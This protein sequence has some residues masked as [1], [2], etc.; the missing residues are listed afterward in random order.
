M[1]QIFAVTFVFELP[2]DL[3]LREPVSGLLLERRSGQWDGWS[4]EG[5]RT[6]LE[7]PPEANLPPDVGPGTRFTLRRQVVRSHPPLLAADRAFADWVEPLLSRSVRLV[8]RVRLGYWRL[9]GIKKPVTVVAV[10]RLVG[11]QDVPQAPDDARALD[12]YRL[13]KPD[14]DRW[15]SLLGLATGR[16]WLS[17]VTDRELPAYIAVITELAGPHGR[18]PDGRVAR[19]GKTFLVPLHDLMP[20][21]IGEE[22]VS[23]EQLESATSAVNSHNAG[24]LS[25]LPVF[26]LLHTAAGE[27]NGGKHEQSLILGTTAIEVLVSWLV[28]EGGPAAGW[29]AARIQRANNTPAFRNRI[30]THVAE[31]LGEVIDVKRAGTRWGEWWARGYAD[32]NRMVHEG[33]R[34][35]Y[36]QA[37]AAWEEVWSLIGHIR[38]RV[39]AQPALQPLAAQLSMFGDGPRPAE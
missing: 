25:V 20:N 21:L 2:F 6:V 17:G 38:D 33:V 18:R 11:A 37:R 39:E 5:I 8:R 16:W 4:E 19:Q 36:A 32:R 3:G 28:R 14:L 29:D 7:L 12:L 34:P 9:K 1:Q 30:E 23:S 15:L 27:L 31:L 24:E 13:A 22:F 10:T 35:S 26:E